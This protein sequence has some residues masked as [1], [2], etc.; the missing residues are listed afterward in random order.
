MLTLVN[1]VRAMATFLLHRGPSGAAAP[2]AANLNPA[3]AAMEARESPAGPWA[4]DRPFCRS[5]YANSA[6]RRLAPSSKK[7]QSDP[8]DR[9]ACYLPSHPPATAAIAV[10]EPAT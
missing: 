9:R 1:N 5:P 7:L 6:C 2:L 8:P 4:V 10:A 3:A